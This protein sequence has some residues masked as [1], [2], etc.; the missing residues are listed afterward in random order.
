M[1]FDRTGGVWARQELAG[2]FGAIVSFAFSL[3]SHSQ[4][5]R[6]P[7]WVFFTCSSRASLVSMEDTK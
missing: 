4:G 6:T 7:T 5:T 1:F 2:K 3:F